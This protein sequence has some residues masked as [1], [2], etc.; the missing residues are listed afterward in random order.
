MPEFVIRE[1]PAADLEALASRAA[2]HGRTAEE[3]ARQLI[4]DAANEELLVSRLERATRAIDAQLRSAERLAG[5]PPPAKR[6]RYRSVEP[7]PRPH[8]P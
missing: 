8:R 7:T 4:H 2:R 6:R 5:S 3:E 1:V